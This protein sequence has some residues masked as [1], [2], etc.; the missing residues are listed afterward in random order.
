MYA[1]RTIIDTIPNFEGSPNGGLPAGIV[2]VY[3]ESMAYVATTEFC[4]RVAAAAQ[5]MP[6]VW[7]DPR[8]QVGDGT[9]LR[10]VPDLPSDTVIISPPRGMD[11]AT[12][13]SLLD[14]VLDGP[15]LISSNGCI[16][17]VDSLPAISD[18]QDEVDTIAAALTRARA[19]CLRTD[20]LL[21][22]GNYAVSGAGGPQAL[23]AH[24]LNALCHTSVRVRHGNGQFGVAVPLC[25]WGVP[26]HE[27]VWYDAYL[28]VGE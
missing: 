22:V 27:F 3:D 26:H 7:I 14:W 17:V 20:S 28:D 23:C 5:H 1:T 24:T 6:T 21:L 18:I 2:T 16:V 13:A 19:A 9:L 12:L 11:A 15:D 8:L 10:A 4:A 25:R